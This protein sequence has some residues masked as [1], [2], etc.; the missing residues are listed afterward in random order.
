MVQHPQAIE[1]RCRVTRHALRLALALAAV[2]PL[3]AAHAPA[4]A[5]GQAGGEA[6]GQ[7]AAHTA[8]HMAGEPAAQTAAQAPGQTAGQAA[9]QAAQQTAELRLLVPPQQTDSRLREDDPPHWV[10]YDTKTA[11]AEAPLLVWLPGTGGAPASGP[12]AFFR[13][14]LQQGLRLLALSTV[15]TPAVSQV[16][17]GATLR[18]HPSCAAQMRQHRVWGE[19]LSSLINDRAED[20]IVPRLTRV[21]QHLARSDPAGQWQQYLDGDAPRWSRLVLAGQSQGGGM[22]A[23][24]AQTRQVAGV[25]MFSGGWDHR[26]G[27][28]IAAWY[29]R[30]SATPPQRWHGTFHVNEPQAAT[31][32]RIYRQLGLAPEHIHALSDP[33]QG[34]QAHGEG[35]RNPVYQ[36]LW[37]RMLRLQR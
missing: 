15:N 11:Q 9:G 37:E 13:T 27:G 22:A 26:L 16:C 20:A 10:A 18:S 28:D 14:A 12:Q 8:A 17:V 34:H 5:S 30:P 24:I 32:E 6:T 25:L 23:Y 21:L 3:L 1:D 19:P 36:P 4:Q 31:M 35:I 29:S 7:T 33:V 2:V